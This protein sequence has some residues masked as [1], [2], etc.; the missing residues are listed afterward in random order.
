[1]GKVVMK[2][3]EA[4]GEAAIRAGCRFYAGYPITPQN[5]VPEYFSRRMHEIDGV[6]VQGESEI[7]SVNMIYGAASVGARAMTSSSGP[8]ISLKAEGISYLA[9]G[10]VPA[11]ILN[12]MR[13][14]PGLGQILV[15]QNDYF[16]A[17]KAP[18]HGGFRMIVLAPSTVQ[19]AIDLTYKAFDLADRDRNPVMLLVDSVIGQMMESVVLPEFK[20]EF[21]DK[22][23][24]I[25]DGCKDRESRVIKSI[26]LDPVL[27]EQMNIESAEMYKGWDKDVEV[28]KYLIDDAEFI[29]TAFGTPARMCK[30][31]IR[32][33]RAD[34]YKVGLIRP[35]T[36]SPFP[37]DA[38]EKLDYDKVKHILS[39]ELT[40]PGQLVEDVKL[41]VRKRASVSFFGCTGGLMMSP[42]DIVDEVK[43]IL[44]KN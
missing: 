23:S 4:I 22:S 43:G 37:C 2:G 7:A 8:G 41:Q 42:D 27:M 3:S 15:S 19:E 16:F 38:Y 12:V 36:L 24:W 6:F 5:D 40:L 17:T 20:T 14:G 39:I 21:P 44:Q 26:E 28:E 29:L 33:L 10:R 25:V 35:I 1:M 32:T 30:S 18:G 13:P 11:V 31:A 9:G 34:G